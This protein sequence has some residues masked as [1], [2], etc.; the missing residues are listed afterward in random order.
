MLIE[1]RTSRL[2]RSPSMTWSQCFQLSLNTFA[3]IQP[4][5]RFAGCQPVYEYLENFLG[6]DL[7]RIL[8]KCYDGRGRPSTPNLWFHHKTFTNKYRRQLQT[9][10]FEIAQLSEQ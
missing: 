8:E 10:S 6:C 1:R 3:Q 9:L 5:Q 7:F 2:Q 4:S